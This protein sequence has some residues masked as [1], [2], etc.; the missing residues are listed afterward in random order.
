MIG[1]TRRVQARCLLDIEHSFD[2][3]HA[4]AVP[5]DVEINPGDV[6][7]LHDAPT[8]IAD[9]ES[10]TRECRITVQRAGPLLQAWTRAVSVFFLTSL[11][12][13]GFDAKDTP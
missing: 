2:S 8:R 11:Y 1:S 12:E 13:V 4:Y 10:L 3:L 9:G 5:Q 7:H 6:V